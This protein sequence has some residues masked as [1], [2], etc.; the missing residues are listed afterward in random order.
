MRKVDEWRKIIVEHF[1]ARIYMHHYKSISHSSIYAW[2]D[3]YENNDIIHAFE[4]LLQDK[5]LLKTKGKDEIFYL[6]DNME[7]TSEIRNIVRKEPFTDRAEKIKPEKQSFKGK[8]ELFNAT[9]ERAW[10][11]R[12][13]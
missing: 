2:M 9:T 4:S 5:I 10:P 13:V 1:V 12:G 6:L 11:N 3:L 8:I 7:K